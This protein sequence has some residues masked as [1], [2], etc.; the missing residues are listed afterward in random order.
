MGRPFWQFLGR[1][2]GNP[3]AGRREGNC[4]W[5]LVSSDSD[6]SDED[7]DRGETALE[8]PS[9]M[10]SNMICE[11]LAL[12]YSEEE[13]AATVDVAIRQDDPAR[14]GL[15]GVDEIEVLQ[16]VVHRRTAASA[17]RPWHGPLPKVRLPSITLQDYFDSG[18]W[19]VV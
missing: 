5:A 19:K 6:E 7:D 4:F 3:A 17:V 1:P 12:G 14:V 8:I 11:S 15:T 18:S 2:K 10:P 9:P 16:R 13:V